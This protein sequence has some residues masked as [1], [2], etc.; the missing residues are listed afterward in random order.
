MFLLLF[1]KYFYTCKCFFWRNK[2]TYLPKEDSKQIV[3]RQKGRIMRLINT[4]KKGEDNEFK[5]VKP[6]R[7]KSTNYKREL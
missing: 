4:M 5:S 7:V 2:P 3:L 6:T 1:I